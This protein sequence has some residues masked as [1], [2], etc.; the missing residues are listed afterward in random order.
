MANLLIL[1]AGYGGI[2]AAKALEKAGQPFTLINKHEYH[3]FTTLL[4]EPAGGRN[5]FE[6]YSVPLRDVLRQP[7]SEI[8]KARVTE[9]KPQG[10]TIVTDRGE[11]AYD[12]LVIALGNAPEYFGIPGMQEHALV[13][14]S[15]DTARQLH[16][17]IE[18]T[19]AAWQEDH[20]DTRLCIVVGGA[21]LTGIELCGELADWMPELAAQYALPL[22]KIQL[23]NLE[24]APTILPMLEEDLRAEA[25]RVLES[26]GVQLRTGTAI[27]KVNRNQVELKTRETIDAQTIIWTGGVRANPLIEQAGFEVDPK[28]RAKVNEFCQSVDFANVFVIGDSAWFT[29]ADGKPLPPTG[30][31]AEQMGDAV[32]QNITAQ[33]QSYPMRPFRYNNLGT[34]AS[35][36]AEVGVGSVKGVRTKGVSAALMKEGSKAKYLWHLG[37][38]RMISQKRGQFKRKG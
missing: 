1:G 29:G 36:G 31:A 13:L 17:H 14:R 4:H 2:A 21:G 9:L 8:V 7:T 22:E 32:A 25:L 16:E 11:L 5:K 19:F 38:L 26:K 10:N 34:L 18:K 37:G 12:Y 20:D 33:L 24:A 27:V 28:G 23:I 6:E 30:Q 3:Y 15:L 35:L